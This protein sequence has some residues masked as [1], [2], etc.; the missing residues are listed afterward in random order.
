MARNFTKRDLN[1]HKKDGRQSRLGS[2]MI[3]VSL[4]NFSMATGKDSDDDDDDDLGIE[5]CLD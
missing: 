5:A 1:G 4:S 2:Q 3:V